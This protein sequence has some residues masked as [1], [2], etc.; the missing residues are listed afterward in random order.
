MQIKG[1]IESV[2]FRNAD[3]GYTVVSLNVDNRLETVVGIFPPVSEGEEVILEGERVLNERYG[4]QIQ[5]N[6]VKTKPP[7]S[8]EGIIKYLS[9]DLFKGI[10]EV[11]ATRIVNKFKDKTFDVIE[12]NPILLDTIQGITAS[13]ALEIGEKYNEL[14]NMQDAI[15]FLQQYDISLNLAIKIF[16]RYRNNTQAIVSSN[17]YQLVYDIEGIGYFTADRI[18][19]KMGLDPK[20]SY[21]IQASINYVLINEANKSGHTYL[22]MKNLVGECIKLLCYDDE[23]IALIENEIEKL[24]DSGEVEI[25]NR[26]GSLSVMLDRF[27]KLEREIARGLIQIKKNFNQNVIDITKEIE[28]YEMINNIDLHESQISAIKSAMNNGGVVITGGPGTGKTTI[29]KCIISLFKSR[30]MSVALCAPTGRAAKRLS[31]ATNEPAMTI[32]RLL[33]LDYSSKRNFYEKEEK[34]EANVIIVDEMSMAD[35]FI[36][37]ALINAID[38]GNRIIIVGDKDQLPSVGAGNVLGDII[39]S[40]IFPVNQLTEIYRQESESYI[41]VNAH[42]INKGVMPSLD[43]KDKDFFFIEVDNLSSL[44]NTI[45]SLCYTRL[46]KYLNVPTNQ[47]QVLCPMKKGLAGVYN[48]NKRLQDVINPNNDIEMSIGEYNFRVGDKVIQ[49]SNNYQIVWSMSNGESGEGVFNGDIGQIEDIDKETLSVSVR[50]EDDKLVAYGAGDLDQLSLAYAITIHKSQ[51]SEF[52]AVVIAVTPGSNTIL[53]RNLL[54]TAVT[55]AKSLV[56]L[57]GDRKTISYMVSNNYTAKRYT[58]LVDFIK[59]LESSD[60]EIN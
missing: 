42:R 26:D 46:P 24:K 5:A 48:I 36:F 6:N 17:P 35:E 38:R 47:I 45:T 1:T 53:T 18:A 3:N 37:M 19:I 15:I 58:C 34:L 25:F 50:F 11:T 56:V 52:E 10:G 31:E 12:N 54:Y 30:N 14:K 41:I 44:V 22:P 28:T 55:R 27:F 21:R 20:S 9:S 59:Q 43:I 13:K 2:I 32:H 8:P 4:E 51:G 16:K 23:C 40:G 29:I 60:V 33:E 39:K 57:V 7:N 49:M